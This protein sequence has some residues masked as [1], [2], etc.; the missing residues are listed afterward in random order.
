MTAPAPPLSREPAHDLSRDALL[1]FIRSWAS[2]L[3][4]RKARTDDGRRA[5]YARFS[6]RG[7]TIDVEAIES[8]DIPDPDETIVR[9]CAWLLY[10]R[11]GIRSR[12]DVGNQRKLETELLEAARS[13]DTATADR[14]GLELVVANEGLAARTP[15]RTGFER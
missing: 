12:L 15:I 8:P 11:L 5:C 4:I 3:R 10:R 1:Y 7:E 6:L 2:D 9:R 13:G 14:I